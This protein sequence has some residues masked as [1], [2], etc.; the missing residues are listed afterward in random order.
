MPDP[1]KFTQKT[2]EAIESAQTKALRLSIRRS[3]PSIF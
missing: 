2:R 1:S 3:M